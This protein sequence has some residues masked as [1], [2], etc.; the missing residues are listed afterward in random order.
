MAQHCTGLSSPSC[1]KQV[2]ANTGLSSPKKHEAQSCSATG[3]SSPILRSLNCFCS[4]QVGAPKTHTLHIRTFPF[5]QGGHLQGAAMVLKPSANQPAFIAFRNRVLKAL[6]PARLARP[7]TSQCHTLIWPEKTSSATPPAW[8]KIP[9]QPKGK[10]PYNTWGCP[11]LY[12]S[13]RQGL[14]SPNIRR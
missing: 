6:Q 4:I 8:S 3:L 12:K 9:G 10:R 7:V 14:S 13:T 2:S 1:P 11:A 5:C